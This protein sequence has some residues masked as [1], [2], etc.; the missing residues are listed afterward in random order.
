MGYVVEDEGLNLTPDTPTTIEG[1]PV[2]S[3]KE[4]KA[5][6]HVT[7]LIDTLKRE[8]STH[9]KFSEMFEGKCKN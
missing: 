5:D 8:V 2:E 7:D 3:S 9:K 1:A 4:K 6:S